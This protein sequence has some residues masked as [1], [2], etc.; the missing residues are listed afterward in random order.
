MRQNIGGVVMSYPGL[1]NLN[2]IKFK[3]LYLKKNRDH[4][5]YISF[6]SSSFCYVKRLHSMSKISVTTRFQY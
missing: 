2:H 3:K 6:T 1:T 5:L 4:R